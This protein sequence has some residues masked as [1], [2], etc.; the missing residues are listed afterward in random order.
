[1]DLVGPYK[2]S[3]PG[4]QKDL[5]LNA[6]TMIDPATGWFE[7]IKIKDK[8]SDTIADIVERTWFSRYPW[9]G[10]VIYD[11]GNEFMSNEFQTNN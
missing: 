11:H 5:V 7:I 10:K 8:R 2:I 6:C 4:K 3:R 9:P 1:M